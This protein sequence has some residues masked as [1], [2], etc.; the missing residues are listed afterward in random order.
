LAHQTSSHSQ[1][2]LPDLNYSLDQVEQQSRRIAGRGIKHAN[3]E[4]GNAC[5]HSP[6][7]REQ[8]MEEQVKRWTRLE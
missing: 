5:V 7:A 2:D 6:F 1:L 4:Q 8:S 3:G